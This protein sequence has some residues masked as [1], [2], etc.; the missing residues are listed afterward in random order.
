MCGEKHADKIFS[1]GNE[2][3]ILFHS[4]GECTVE[5]TIGYKITVDLGRNYRIEIF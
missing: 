5:C 1:S 2:L 3:L 4:D